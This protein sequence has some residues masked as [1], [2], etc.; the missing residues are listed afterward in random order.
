[1]ASGGTG[2]AGPAG[3]D[4]QVTIAQKT[5]EM[6]NNIEAVSTVDEIYKYDRKQQQ[7]ILTTK[8]WERE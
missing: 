2:G 1:M 3:G 7:D 8:P 6:T 5:W 4:S